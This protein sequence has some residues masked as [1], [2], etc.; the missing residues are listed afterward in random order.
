MPGPQ[1]KGCIPENYY[2]DTCMLL[3]LWCHTELFW[4]SPEDQSKPVYAQSGKL[5]SYTLR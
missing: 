1:K 5:Y 4:G 3:R 2:C